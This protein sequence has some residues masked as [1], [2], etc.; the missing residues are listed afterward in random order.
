MTRSRKVWSWA[1]VWRRL[2]EPGLPDTNT[3][4]PALG[5]LAFHGR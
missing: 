5:A 2:V 1:V 3:G 4:S